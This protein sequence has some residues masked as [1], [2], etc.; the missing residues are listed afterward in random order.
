MNVSNNDACDRSV[1]LEAI[2]SRRNNAHCDREGQQ[3]SF[4]AEHRRFPLLE[5]CRELEADVPLSIS[6]DYDRAYAEC[7]S[8]CDFVFLRVGFPGHLLVMVILLI[9]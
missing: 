6:L 1:T 3:N 9:L 8:T 4:F 7:A 5:A 2:S